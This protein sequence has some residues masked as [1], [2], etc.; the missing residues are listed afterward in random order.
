MTYNQALNQY[1]KKRGRPPKFK[2]AKVLIIQ[3]R[4][5]NR[6]LNPAPEW[7][8][9]TTFHSKLSRNLIS[10]ARGDCSIRILPSVCRSMCI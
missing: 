3:S 2:T 7:S 6:M 8:G 10:K 1:K 9:I 5:V 4:Y